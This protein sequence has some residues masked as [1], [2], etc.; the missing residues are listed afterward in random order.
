MKNASELLKRLTD[1]GY[2]NDKELNKLLDDCSEFILR[3]EDDEESMIL[4]AQ[5][6]QS[7]VAELRKE[8]DDLIAAL[9]KSDD[10]YLE[11][12]QR[13]ARQVPSPAAVGDVTEDHLC[14]DTAKRLRRVCGLLGLANAIPETD[15]ELGGVVFSVLGMIARAIEK[16]AAAVPER[17]VLDEIEF[18]VAQ[19]KYTAAQLYT[20]MRWLITRSPAPTSAGVP[21]ERGS[22]Y[23]TDDELADPEYMR[24]YVDELHSIIK[25]IAKHRPASEA[26]TTQPAA[27]GGRE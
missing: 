2:G 27:D 10:E 5:H 9:K 1:C 16:P 23:L 21:D 7:E 22:Q 25:D 19:G 6:L 3:A 20:K 17:N 18:D 15:K 14:S 12:E 13:L 4:N 8:R 26:T 24:A 11:L